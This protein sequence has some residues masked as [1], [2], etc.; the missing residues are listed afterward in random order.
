MSLPDTVYQP[1]AFKVQEALMLGFT[2]LM[3]VLGVLGTAL[4]LWKK[5]RTTEICNMLSLALP[6]TME[7]GRL[8]EPEAAPVP[9]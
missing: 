4:L 2:S 3:S 1:P 5:V 7:L 9:S 6:Y 8:L